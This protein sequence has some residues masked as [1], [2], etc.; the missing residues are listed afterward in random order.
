MKKIERTRNKIRKS[1]EKKRKCNRNTKVE[2]MADTN[3]KYLT[4]SIFNDILYN[5]YI[6]T[7]LHIY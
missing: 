3:S 5:Y 7:Y 1:K 6:Y 2:N 4:M